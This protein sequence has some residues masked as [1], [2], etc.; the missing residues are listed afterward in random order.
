M[1]FLWRLRCLDV[2]ELPRET[3]CAG[4]TQVLRFV[5][6]MRKHLLEAEAAPCLEGSWRTLLARRLGAYI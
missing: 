6:I 2:C 3:S 4:T 5:R 1:E